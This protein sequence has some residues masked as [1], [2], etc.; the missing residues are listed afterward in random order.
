MTHVVTVYTR[1][2]CHLCDEALLALR[3]LHRPGV[4]VEAVD[5][6][7]D[8]R[9]LARYVERIPVIALDGTELYDFHVDIDD[10]KLRLDRLAA[11]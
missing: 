5:I 2:G 9:L 1:A 8:D 11:R 7:A 3:A 6:E 10:L 4:R